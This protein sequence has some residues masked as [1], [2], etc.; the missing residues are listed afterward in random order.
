MGWV[1]ISG[2]K[3]CNASVGWERPVHLIQ[4]LVRMQHVGHDGGVLMMKLLLNV[5]DNLLLLL[6]EASG[7]EVGGMGVGWTQKQVLSSFSE[8]NLQRSKA[9]RTCSWFW[10]SVTARRRLSTMN[11]DWTGC[12]SFV[13]QRE[14]LDQSFSDSDGI[15]FPPFNQETADSNL[16]VTLCKLLS[17]CCF[18]FPLENKSRTCWINDLVNNVSTGPVYME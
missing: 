14:V 6:V 3:W 16:Y 2:R 7:C 4:S 11:P 5:S 15:I 12:W 1:F 8:T 17:R 13:V 9:Q 18:F 10:C